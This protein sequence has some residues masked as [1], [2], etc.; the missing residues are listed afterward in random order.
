MSDCTVCMAVLGRCIQLKGG[1]T[2][3]LVKL[4]LDKDEWVEGEHR[5]VVV[6]NLQ[7]SI[8]TYHHNPPHITDTLHSTQM[9][10]HFSVHDDVCMPS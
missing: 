4:Y 3:S 10:I 1:P 5:V 2:I 9:S 8:I 7:V 6:A